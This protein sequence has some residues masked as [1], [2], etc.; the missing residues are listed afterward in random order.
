[1]L[2]SEKENSTYDNPT[3]DIERS[4]VFHV[5]D[6]HIFAKYKPIS[7]I[8]AN[9]TGTIKKRKINKGVSII[10]LS[11]LTGEVVVLSYS[12]ACSES[13]WEN[14]KSLKRGDMVQVKGSVK[15]SDFGELCI[16]AY[17]ILLL[18][19]AGL[20]LKDF[21]AYTL[22]KKQS[23]KQF[24]L[25]R[26]R[27]RAI[28][29]LKSENFIEFIP[30]IIE[31]NFIPSIIEQN[32]SYRAY[33]K[34]SPAKQ[35]LNALLTSFKP[36][37]CISHS[38]CS[39][40]R[41]NEVENL[42]MSACFFETNCKVEHFAEKM[43]KYILGSFYTMPYQAKD[44]W[45]DDL[46]N[47]KIDW[48]IEEYISIP[49]DFQNP[50][51][52]FPI[53]QIFKNSVQSNPTADLE[54]GSQIQYIYRLVWPDGIVLAEGHVQLIGDFKVKSMT[55]YLERMASLILHPTRL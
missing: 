26:L 49:E 4:E 2:I 35:V 45:L 42:I 48:K 41:N 12:K 7:S 43:L 44:I 54:L 6:L 37:F 10:N 3:V 25:G 53:I 39:T 30:S 9:I 1:M 29:F 33:L 11:E 31:Q 38:F 52:E 23:A 47:W 21:S 34:R 36:V 51:K 14:I 55:I 16:V 28:E 13:K 46:N 50:L 5:R 17:E 22:D 8:T 15:Y 32:Q 27:N 40:L 20:Y 24:M 19:E 18:K